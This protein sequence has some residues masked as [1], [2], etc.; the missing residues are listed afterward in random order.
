[1]LSPLWGRADEVTMKLLSDEWPDARTQIYY[2]VYKRNVI[3]SDATAAMLDKAEE[4]VA[5]SCMS[6]SF[7][8][9][10]FHKLDSTRIVY[11]VNKRSYKSVTKFGLFETVQL[12]VENKPL[13][14]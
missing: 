1:M 13:L 7:L 4:D 11:T 9:H 14:D 2:Q 8:F 6:S 3:M 12:T 10:I 5:A